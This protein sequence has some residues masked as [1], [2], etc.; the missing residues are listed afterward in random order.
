M[1]R[2]IKKVAMKYKREKRC[3][4]G[5]ISLS[6]STPRWDVEPIDVLPYHSTRAEARRNGLDRPPHDAE[7]PLR[8]TR[9]IPLVIDG[10]HHG[11]EQSV[12]G[13][14]VSGV[15]AFVVLGVDLG[16]ADR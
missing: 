6:S 11:L 1:A 16:S 15:P 5:S 10:D 8:Q 7:P 3:C 14:G 13:F 9:R 12:E 2:R 4:L